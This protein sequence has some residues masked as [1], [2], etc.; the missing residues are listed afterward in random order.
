MALPVA[1]R[2]TSDALRRNPVLFVPIVALLSIQLPRVAFPAIGPGLANAV[3]LAVL[4]FVQGGLVGM[5]DEALDG[6]TSL[7]TFGAEGKRTYVSI[8]V[9]SLLLL[10]VTVAIGV[11]VS[12]A[13]VVVLFARY[14]GGAGDAGVLV[15]VGLAVVAFVG[16]AYLL[17]VFFLQFYAQAI[18]VDDRG[19][20]DSLGRSVALVRAN[21]A[22]AV[23]Y[24]LGVG[25]L[26]GVAGGLCGVAAVTA[27]ADVAVPEVSPA[28]VASLVLVVVAVGTLV[29]GF[30]GVFS[31]AFY[32]TMTGFH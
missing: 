19:S 20:L 15:A 30:L 31:V 12:V 3:S 28:G 14:P 9:V 26:T 29:G 5:A 18:V 17:V 8:L 11:V 10:A 25:L 2:R 23:G 7:A 22:S 27:T 21:L 4:P 32:R 1:F 16:L 24:S 13:G 6:D